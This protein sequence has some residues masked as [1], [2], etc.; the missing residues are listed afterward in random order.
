MIFRLANTNSILWGEV[1][2][3]IT[4]MST[5]IFLY[6]TSML[7]E[8]SVIDL[9]DWAYNVDGV[10]YENAFGDVMPVSGTLN[11]EGLGSLT[12]SVSGGGLH[13]MRAFFDFDI[14]RAI[15]SSYNESGNAYGVAVAGQSWEIDEPGWVFGDIYDHVIPISGGIGTL[16][17]TNSVPAG[18]EDDV[19]F[20]LGW[21]FVLGVDEI[22]TISLNLS[23]VLDTSGFY[24][25]H[26]D[27]ET[28]PGFNET[29]TIY[30][31]STLNISVLPI[32]VPSPGTL[33]LLPVG[34][35]LLI[36]KL[37]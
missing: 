28:G 5:A 10:T 34:L 24:L 31:W 27:A 37:R 17:N 18:Q 22:A 35:A 3:I 12:L 11:T 23:D 6:S 16:D 25:A 14:D 13:S 32:Q 9:V 19:S 20:A 2:K 21:D 29:T 1:M 15:N 7:A 33:F 4:T 26:S 30:A 36:L 8:A